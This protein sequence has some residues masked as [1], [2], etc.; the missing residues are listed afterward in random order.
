MPTGSL[1]VNGSVAGLSFSA[2]VSATADAAL[3][4]ETTLPAGASGTLSTRTDND[5]GVVTAA[6]HTFSGSGS[7]KCNVF[8]SGGMRY[9]MTVTA[10]DGNDISIDTGAGDNLPTED[11]EVIISEQVEINIDFDGDDMEMLVVGCDQ[12]CSADFQDSGGTVLLHKEIPQPGTGQKNLYSWVDG[13]NGTRPITGNA[14]DK[15]MASNA[16]VTEAT[17]QI[18][19][20][21]NS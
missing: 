20:L 4:D 15:V 1:S 18:G 10:V 13:V 16:T 2:Q 17:L 3:A 5:T 19:V 7:E 6:G 14:V 21:I 12:R 8:W 11:A 9:G